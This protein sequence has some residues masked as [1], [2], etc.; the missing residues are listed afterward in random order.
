MEELLSQLPGIIVTTI[1]ILG[2]GA[3]WRFY[4]KK[5]LLN[6][7]TKEAEAD[8]K[9]IERLEQRKNRDLFQEDLRERV[10]RL[11]TK[12]EEAQREITLLT[13]RSS[14]MRAIILLLHQENKILKN[15]FLGKDVE[16]DGIEGLI[17]NNLEELLRETL[18]E[19]VDEKE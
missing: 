6:Q 16:L 12:L 2:S 4:E 14:G 19:S 13:E 7:K 15:K 18:G 1:T 17:G 3:A 5:L 10:L 8:Q 9:K 11:E